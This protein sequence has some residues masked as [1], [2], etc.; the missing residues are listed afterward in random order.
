MN[1]KL[2]EANLRRLKILANN[3]RTES[4][5]ER[6]YLSSMDELIQQSLSELQ[7]PAELPSFLKETN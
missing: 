7:A 4:M 6:Y 5:T 1:I 2:V 3:I